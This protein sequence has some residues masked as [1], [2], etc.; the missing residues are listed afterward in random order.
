M[1]TDLT[2]ILTIER[3]NINDCKPLFVSNVMHVLYVF[4]DNACTTTYYV[5]VLITTYFAGKSVRV[6]FST[7]L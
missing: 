4:Q 6:G 1:M 7:Q 5:F 2:S 3:F